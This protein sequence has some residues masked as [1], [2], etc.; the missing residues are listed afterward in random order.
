MQ[1]MLIAV[2]VR[3]FTATPFSLPN[4]PYAHCIRRLP[5]KLTSPSTSVDTLYEELSNAFVSA[6]DLA[7]LAISHDPADHPAGPPSVRKTAK[8]LH[9]SFEMLGS[10]KVHRTLSNQ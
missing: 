8:S 5:S 1:P 6:L 4:I 3:L 2:P 9:M 7:F 10:D